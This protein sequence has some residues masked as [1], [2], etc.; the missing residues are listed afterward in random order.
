MASTMDNIETH[1]ENIDKQVLVLKIGA[2][3]YYSNSECSVFY[4]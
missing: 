1:S 2:S 4:T 3:K